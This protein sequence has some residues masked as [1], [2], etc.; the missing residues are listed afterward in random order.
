M[1]FKLITDEKRIPL[2]HN[3]G[4]ADFPYEYDKKW[5]PLKHNNGKTDFPDE[6]DGKWVI[7]TDGT[8]ISVERIKKD[9]YDHF[10]PNGRW[11]ELSDA[12]AW[13]PL[14]NQINE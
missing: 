5:I 1:G 6:Y 10:Y 11:F 4:K 2:K 9:A 3:N 14:P 13:M 7:V 8:N 12:V